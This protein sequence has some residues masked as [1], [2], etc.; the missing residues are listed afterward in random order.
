[1]DAASYTAVFYIRA[2]S[3]AV[4]DALT[5]ADKTQTYW[6]DTRLESTWQVGAELLFVRNGA[7]TD[8]NVVLEVVEPQLLRYS[9]KPLFADFAAEQPSRVSIFLDHDN[10]VTRLTIHHDEF[11]P[12]SSV[13]PAVRVGWPM[14]L[15]SLK[16]LLECGTPLPLATFPPNA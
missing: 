5:S 12:Q 7:V 15:S 2:T 4:W 8:R 9:F 6:H 13:L 14:I 10:G 11:A 16:S 1:M 3:E